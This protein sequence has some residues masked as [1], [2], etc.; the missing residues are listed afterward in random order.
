MYTGAHVSTSGGL[1]KAIERGKAIGAESL[2]IFPSAPVQWKIRGWSDEE[3]TEF[4]INWTKDYKQV[5]FHGIYLANLAGE[6]AENLEKTKVSLIDTLTLADKLGI[7]GTV[8]HPGNYTQGEIRKHDQIKNSIS[9][10]LDATPKSTKLIFEN[11]AGSTMGGKIEDLAW[12]IDVSSDK[13]RVGVCLDTCH[14]FAAGYDIT[15]EE[16]YNKYLKKVNELIGLENVFCWHLNDSKFG[17][18]EK[19]DRHEN[20]G[21]GKIGK[22]TFELLMN[23]PRWENVSGYLEVPG[24]ENQGPDLLNIETLKNLRKK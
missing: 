17:L 14:A 22:T 15:D 6:S 4:K 20:I 23:D 9:E 19:R 2:Q 18:G 3:A 5:V 10:V 8:F 7:V 24:Y 11:T 21:E 12:L 1:N 16:S 13:S